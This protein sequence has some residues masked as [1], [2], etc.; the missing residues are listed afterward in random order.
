MFEKVRRPDYMSP[1][2]PASVGSDVLVP[3]LQAA[4]TSVAAGIVAV[5]IVLATGV[6]FWLAVVAPIGVFVWVWLKLMTEH[7]DHLWIKEWHEQPEAAPSNIQH[8]TRL[9]VQVDGGRMVETEFPIAHD[10]MVKIA[11]GIVN[12][13]RPFSEREWSGQGRL[14]AS[15]NEFREIRGRLMEMGLLTWK[16]EQ[17]RNLGVEWTPEGWATLQQLAA[18]NAAVEGVVRNG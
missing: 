18:G 11:R 7:N 6:T 14:L 1:A 9:T 3:L 16:D 10:V 4:V 2:R 15:A 12:A 5:L 17:R 13:G 8:I